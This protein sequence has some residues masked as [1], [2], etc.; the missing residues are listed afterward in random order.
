MK[1]TPSRA[2][3]WEG[4]LETFARRVRFSIKIVPVV[5]FAFVDIDECASVSCQNGGTCI[6]GINEFTCDCV[7]GH[8]GSICDIGELFGLF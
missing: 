4:I 1:L 3:A 2:C 8:T 7:P 5:T 6:D